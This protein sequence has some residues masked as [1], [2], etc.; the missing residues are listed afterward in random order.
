MTLFSM[1]LILVMFLVDRYYNIL[2]SIFLPQNVEDKSST[3]ILSNGNILESH[4]VDLGYSNTPIFFQSY[5]CA[6]DNPIALYEFPY[7]D[8]PIVSFIQKITL[9]DITEAISVRG[10][11]IM[12]NG[13]GVH[14]F[15]NISD[16]I[17]SFRSNCSLG[18]Y[19]VFRTWMLSANITAYITNN[20]RVFSDMMR[21]YVPF[22]FIVIIPPIIYFIWKFVSEYFAK[23][24]HKHIP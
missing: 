2:P 19:F 10:W 3:I 18:D 8:S 11:M 21:S 22:E 16:L 1:L 4:G 15:V 14:G 5:K 12:S 9:A 6:I 13:E 24:K 20:R 23:V 17:K 7:R